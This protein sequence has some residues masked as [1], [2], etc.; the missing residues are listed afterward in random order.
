MKSGTKN[1]ENQDTLRLATGTNEALLRSEISFWNDMIAGCDPAHPVESLERMQQAL[2]LAESR[3]D[4]LFR[5]Y[6]HAYSSDNLNKLPS[7]V[8]SISRSGT[9][10]ARKSK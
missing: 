9:A 10:H 8:Y 2:A 7:N 3:L 6:Q 5:D 1:N 4:T